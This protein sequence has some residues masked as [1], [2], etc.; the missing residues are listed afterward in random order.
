MENLIKVALMILT[1]RPS[2]QGL[3]TRITTGALCT[4]F[5][6][7][8]LA[9]GVACGL[10]GLWIYLIPVVGPVGAALWIAAIL[11]FVSAMMMLVARA[12]FTAGEVDD[13]DEAPALGEEL[14]SGLLEGFSEN[15]TS[16]LLAALVA[17][18]VA[19]GM[20]KRS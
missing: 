11:L 1:D 17:G 10:A 3:G 5:A 6:L 4:G 18:L 12:M 14:L 8:T 2:R 20:N 16:V 9:A 15:K 7:I 19:G 13:D